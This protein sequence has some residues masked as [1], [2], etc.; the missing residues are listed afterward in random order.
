[1]DLV[2]LLIIGA[3]LFFGSFYASWVF[4]DAWREARAGVRETRSSGT[5]VSLSAWVQHGLTLVF[6]AIF[7]A[8]AV[9]LCFS[10]VRSESCAAAVAQLRSLGAPKPV[11]IGKVWGDGDNQGTLH[12]VPASGT[13]RV[14]GAS[15]AYI[16][17]DNSDLERLL[18][19]HPHIHWFILSGTQVDDGA[20][21]LLA[22][23]GN[24]DTLVLTDTAITDDGFTEFYGHPQLRELDLTRT[25]ITDRSLEVLGSLPMLTHLNI[26][27]TETTNEGLK[28]LAGKTTLVTLNIERT[29]ITDAAIDTLATL[30][31]PEILAGV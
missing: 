28:A 20:L 21:Q 16:R 19:Q 5:G 4:W 17:F 10:L 30:P 6:S 25:A 14:T 11:R 15:L 1:M 27:Q 23:R 7:L 13:D 29:R 26:S 2:G 22:A 3:V 24:L 31:K 18:A 8:V 9:H 12:V